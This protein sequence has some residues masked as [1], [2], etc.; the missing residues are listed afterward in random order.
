MNLRFLLTLFLMC[1]TSYG[2]LAQNGQKRKLLFL[3]IDGVRSDALQKANTPTIDSLIATSV[4]T[5]DSWHLGITVSG[6]SWSSMLTGVSYLKHGVTNNS[7]T[8]S[9]FDRYPYLTTLAKTL[10]PEL[11][12]V[13]IVEWPPLSDN[14]YNDSWNKKLKTPDGDGAATAAVAMQEIVAPSLDFMFVYFDQCDLAGHSSGFSPDNPSYIQAIENVDFQV[15]KV[16]GALQSRANYA[17]EDWLILIC[18]DHGGIGTGHGGILPQERRIWWIGAGKGVTKQQ[19]FGPDP[20]SYRLPGGVDKE[21]VRLSPV[22]EDIAVTGLHHLIYDLNI[23][24]EDQP[25]WNLDGKSWLNTI[26]S[27]T[28]STNA[29]AG[30][31]VQ[32]LVV[33]PN[34]SSGETHIWVDTKPNETLHVRLIDATGRVEVL[35]FSRVN[36]NKLRVDLSNHVCG[37]YRLEVQTGERLQHETIVIK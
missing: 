24:P 32:R 5:F 1:A 37:V 3:G 21:K 16:L 13:Q 15:R 18:T 33:Y 35:P 34:P 36:D 8:G 12:C 22:Q 11:N 19:I 30:Q 14:V 4:H 31:A 7:Y 20:G 27:N 26:Y 10:K 25:A 9:R 17:N 28:T 6:P 29:S 2:V 23:N